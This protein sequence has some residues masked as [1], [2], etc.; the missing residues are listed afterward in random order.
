MIDVSIVIIN[1]N[2]SLLTYNCV[3]SIMETTPME[4]S[5]EIIV[6]DNASKKEDFLDL[7]QKLDALHNDKIRL[8]RSRINTGFASGNMFGVQFASG[9]YLAFINNDVELTADSFTPLFQYF[10]AHPDTGVMGIQPVFADKRTQVAF[11]HFDTFSN[12]FFGYWLYE[13]LNPT[14]AKRHKVYTEPVQTDYVVGSFMLFKA[15]HFNAIGGFDTNIFLYFE[16]MDICK[17]LLNH[18][19]KTIFFP[20]ID[21]VHING[22]STNLGY[23]KKIELKISHLYIVRKNH[24][25]FS[26]ALLKAFFILIFLF[27]SIFNPKHFRL[28]FKL[29][30]LGPPM[31]SSI[32]HQQKIQ[33]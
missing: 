13:K 11:G 23:T 26:Y 10:D 15:A 17:R 14:K 3:V 21:Y 16:E 24:G 22:A 7:Q 18:N 25:F 32:R 6:V 9:N 29:I 2:T 28:L 1:Y 27:K 30:A 19:L 33:P 12:R 31:A 4:I 8:I 20:S 5:Y